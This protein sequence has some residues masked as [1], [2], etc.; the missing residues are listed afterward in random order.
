MAG[1][2]RYER[3]LRQAGGDWAVYEATI[4]QGVEPEDVLDPSFWG[5]H[6]KMLRH[7]DQIR[8]EAEDGSWMMTLRIMG[9]DEMGGR[10]LVMLVGDLVRFDPGPIPDGYTLE[11]VSQLA[12]WRVLRDGSS[13]PVRSGFASSYDA[14]EWLR[15]DRGA[16]P[17]PKGK[18]A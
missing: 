13:G 4:P 6:A 16:M 11:F 14:A 8:V 5:N 18:A 17:K 15:M 12:G 10:V 9:K 7:R 2:R 1:P 3:R